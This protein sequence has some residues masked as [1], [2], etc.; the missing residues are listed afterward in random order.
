MA[1]SLFAS[2]E[3]VRSLIELGTPNQGS[4]L[5]NMV[6]EVFKG[7]SNPTG[8][9]ADE[10]Y[11]NGVIAAQTSTFLPYRSSGKHTGSYGSYGLHGEPYAIPCLASDPRK[12]QLPTALDTLRTQPLPFY[13]D[14]SINSAELA[15]LNA[16]PFNPDVSYAAVIG[17]A[18]PTNYLSLLEP[19]GPTGQSL[20][21][22][23]NTFNGAGSDGVVP[24]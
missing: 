5:A 9:A 2:R 20:F 7:T 12:L 13:Q 19:I 17:T 15:Q 6:D 18:Q 1:G 4:P 21:P 8:Q 24:G 11:T 3:D 22:W 16:N 23:M 10:S 14:A